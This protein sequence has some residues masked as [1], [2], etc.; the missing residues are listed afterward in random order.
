MTTGTRRAIVLIGSLVAVLLVVGLAVPAVSRILQTTEQVYHQLPG[1]LH[2]LTLDGEVGEITVRAAGEGE[3]PSAQATI[4]SGL[5]ELSADA[6]IEGDA[7]LLTDTCR[8]AWWTNCSVD[9]SLVVQDDTALII[10]S[11][12]GDITVTETTGQLSITTDV[13]D[14]S[15][16]GAEAATVRTDSSVG[17]ITVALVTPPQDL[18]AN[19]STGDVTVTVPDDATAYRVLTDTSVGEVTN[20]LGSDPGGSSVI[21]VRTSVGDITLRRG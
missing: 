18:Q 12:V 21:D 19:S 5:T 7:A 15:V 13:G 4:R 9:W 20:E 1:Q 8:S 16:A 3:A 6:T 10:T 11:S 2:S 14:I 17:D